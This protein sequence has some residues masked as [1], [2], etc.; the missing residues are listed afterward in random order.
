MWNDFSSVTNRT[1]YMYR[2]TKIF[3]E[4]SKINYK[5]DAVINAEMWKMAGKLDK[6][7]YTSSVTV[8]TVT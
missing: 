3:G 6:W 2:K 8:T 5:I 1:I 4:N 7:L